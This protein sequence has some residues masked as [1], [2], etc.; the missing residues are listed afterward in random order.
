MPFPKV[1]RADFPE[2][3]GI[4]VQNGRAVTVQIPLVPEDAARPPEPES[5]AA[6]EAE[7]ESGA[8]EAQETADASASVTASGPAGE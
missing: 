1:K 7:A 2:G 8:P 6:A 5:A 3:R 4:F